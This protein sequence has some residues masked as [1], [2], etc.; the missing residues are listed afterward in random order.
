MSNSAE[1]TQPRPCLRRMPRGHWLEAGR[2]IDPALL[3][4]LDAN[5][6]K[7]GERFGDSPSDKPPPPSRREQP[8]QRVLRSL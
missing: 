4:W 2:V 1:A 6:E 3:E 8:R 5:M 7:V